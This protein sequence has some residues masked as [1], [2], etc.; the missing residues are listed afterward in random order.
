DVPGAALWLGA[1]LIIGSGLFIV[2]SESR[3]APA[4]AR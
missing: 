2:Y 3:P 1:A 4:G